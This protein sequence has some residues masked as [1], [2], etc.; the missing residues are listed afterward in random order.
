[1]R[2]LLRLAANDVR[3]TLR[4]RASAFWLFALP[5]FLIWIFGRMSGGGAPPHVALTVVDRDGG[6][7]AQAFAEEL[8]GP[9]V[10]LTI[11]AGTGVTSDTVAAAVRRIELPAG[12]TEGA[13]SGRQQKLRI[14]V[15][16]NA[17]ADNTRAADVVATRAIVRTLARV[18]ELRETKAP[19]DLATYEA[20]K[21]RPALIA[22]ETSSAGHGTAV[23]GMEQSVPGNL[24]FTVMMMTLI[25]GAVF[26]TIEK[27]E[28]MI[29]RQ[30]TLP[31]SRTTI[32]AGKV[33]GRLFIAILQ[34]AVLLAVGRLFFHVGYGHSA[35]GLWTLLIAYAFAVAGIATFLGAILANPE[36]A[37]TVG[38]LSSTVMGALGGCW[39]PAEI[40]PDWL[41]QAAHVFPTAWAMD[42]LHALISFGRG[43]DAVVVP[44]AM[45]A[46]FGVVFSW[47]AARKL[48]ATAG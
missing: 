12:F 30:L 44:S 46:G 35:L 47:L 34:I 39:W 15:A 26:L 33:L 11:L 5:V 19:Q 18:A 27:R 37:S 2:P 20:L 41:R 7:L 36:Q 13:L 17:S 40:M 3:L 6:W 8:R 43:F 42:G 9:N 16:E 23:R 38:W 45:L 28:G 48:R 21:A 24:T 1:M 32:F 10:E 25:Y 14:E 29:K 4:D 22:V 31:L